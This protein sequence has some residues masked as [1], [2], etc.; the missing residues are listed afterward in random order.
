MINNSKLSERWRKIV[1]KA[2]K[3]IPYE[4]KEIDK[5]AIVEGINEFYLSLMKGLITHLSS[6]FVWDNKGYSRKGKYFSREQVINDFLSK[7]KWL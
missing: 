1:D 6:N 7:L 5:E 2:V 3:E 4:G